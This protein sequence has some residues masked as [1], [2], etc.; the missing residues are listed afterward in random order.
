MENWVGESEALKLFATHYQTGEVIPDDLIS[1]IKKSSNFGAGYLSLRQL[2]LG[3]LDMAWYTNLDK[4][5]DVEEFERKAT[6]K[7]Q[8]F[9]SIPGMTVSN[10]FG[11]IFSGG[12]SA[13]Y[14]SY[15][16]AEVL[17][18]DAF[19][20]FKEDGIFNTDT[21]QSFRENILSKGSLK[22]PMQLYKAF[23]GREPQVE[24]LLRRDNLIK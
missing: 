12:Y 5:D 11:H 22:H 21:A 1:K 7:T 14:Y 6:E 9:P 3:Y 20:K 13:G 18:A 17:D 8:L 15:K 16:W 4:V 2:S 10:S 19:E 24:A 23:R